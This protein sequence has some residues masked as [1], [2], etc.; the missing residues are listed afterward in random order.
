MNVVFDDFFSGN[1]SQ[2]RSVLIFRGLTCEFVLSSVLFIIKRKANSLIEQQKCYGPF[3]FRKWSLIFRFPSEIKSLLIDP[4]SQIGLILSKKCESLIILKIS[5]N[6][7]A[8][9]F[10]LEIWKL[11][12]FKKSKSVFFL[13]TCLD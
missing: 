13:L 6:F 7:K 1:C 5:K 2:S 12:F 8:T 9:F 4:F 3:S 10:F 11:T